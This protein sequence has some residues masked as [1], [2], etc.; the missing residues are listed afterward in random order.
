MA[1][2]DRTKEI[3]LVPKRVNL[4][5]TIC[6]IDGLIDRK[7]DGT[8]WNESKQDN[9]GVNLKKWGATNDGKNISHQSVRTLLAS[10]PQYLGF[11][12]IDTKTTPSTIHITEAGMQLWK[13]HVGEL[14]KIPNLRE[15]QDLII[16]ESPIVLQQ[17]EKLQITNPIIS[18]D[19]EN[20]L[21][22]TFRFMLR[23]LQK[24]GYL[25]KEELAYF[26]FKVRND[27]EVD[28]L[29]QE[30]KNFRNLTTEDRTSL[31]NAFRN[32]QIGNITLVKAPSSRYYIS[33]C[34]ITGII[35]CLDVEP[36]NYQGKISALKIKQEYLEYVAEILDSKY[37]NAKAY[38]FEDNLQ[39]WMDYMGT[40]SRLYP[41]IDIVLYNKTENDFLLQLLK[42]DK[43]INDDFLQGNS[44]ITYPMFVD[45]AYSIKLIDVN[46]GD[47][48]ETLELHP[49]FSDREFEITTEHLK[50]AKRET[51][52]DLRIEIVEHCNASYF[53]GKMLNYL[54]AL[55]KVTG[56][57][58]TRD[59]SLR[60]A[61]LEYLFFKLLNALKDKNVIDDVMWNGR[62]GKYNLPVPAPGGKTGTPDIVFTVDGKD[63]VLELTTIKPKAMQFS[64][65]GASVPDH[66]KLYRD[67]TGK[68]VSGVFSA[69]IIH[70][71]NEQSMKSTIAGYGI[72]LECL[73]VEELVDLLV[74]ENKDIIKKKLM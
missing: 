39:L 60:G 14:V 1:Q 8:T 45:E 19:C 3:W 15:G 5:Q 53:D 71:R 34:A 29:E 63:V 68:D 56:K 27:D 70:E 52:E 6:L 28:V 33:L 65:E 72:K 74:T 61:Y 4:H 11:V 12:F 10:I 23:L 30:I 2:K 13:E 44:N 7:Y 9:L 20:I 38:D 24:L 59:G 17:M 43:I 57:D 37:A 32:T 31:I 55:K 25:D 58:K 35:D 69:P 18:K 51:I 54:N 16:S 26:L 64:A 62:I 50:P 67:D 36:N 66:I 22:F 41:P 42:D 21:F 48:I 73:P 47:D 49:S 46:S 40:P